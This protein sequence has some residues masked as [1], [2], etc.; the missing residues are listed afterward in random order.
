[1][2]TREFRLP[3]LGEGLTE[4]ELVSWRVAEGDTV[5]LNQIIAEVETAK[6]LVE[7]PSPHAGVIARLYVEAGVTVNVGDPIVAFTVDGSI[8]GSVAGPPIKESSPDESA[9]EKVPPNL[10]GY[11]AMAESNGAP[12]RRRRNISN[13]TT[14]VREPAAPEA[15][16]LLPVVALPAAIPVPRETLDPHPRRRSTP[17]VRRLAQQLGVDLETLIGTGERGLVTRTDVERNRLAVGPVLTGDGASG[18]SWNAVRGVRKLMAQAMVS[19]AFTAPHVTVFLTVDVTETVALLDRLR[20]T[21]EFRELRLTFLSAVSR[22]ACIVMSRHPAINSR[23]D[24]AS[25]GIFRYSQVNLG[26]AA[27]TP[28]G[29]IV[30]VISGAD[31]LDLAALATSLTELTQL[32]KADRTSPADLSGGTFTISNI[33]VFGV[34]AGTPILNN[35]EAAILALGVVAKR[36]WEFGGELALR[37]I[38]TLSLSFDHRVLDGAEGS[39]FIS[40]V[41]RLLRD[42]ASA[43]ALG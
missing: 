31:S 12:G 20:A 6:A 26:I 15:S 40:D 34:D 39:R 21:P 1:M 18:E 32:A 4:S 5:V 16:A 28:R 24:E 23:W 29:L 43:F 27:A 30:P 2:A 22:A 17:P 37:H 10:V 14:A 38:T 41:G 11:G 7:L 35:G 8:E 36:P 3:D 25:G 9:T 33:G 13:G 42:P 19:S